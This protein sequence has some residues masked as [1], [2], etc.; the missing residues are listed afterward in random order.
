MKQAR[1]TRVN[2]NLFVALWRGEISII[3]SF[4]SS[5]CGRHIK[6]TQLNTPCANDDIETPPATASPPAYETPRYS[7]ASVLDVFRTL[8]TMVAVPA[9]KS[10][11]SLQLGSKEVNPHRGKESAEKK[12]ISPSPESGPPTVEAKN[13]WVWPARG[14][15]DGRARGGQARCGAGK[16]RE[17][18]A[19]GGEHANLRREKSN[20]N[21]QEDDS[22]DA[23]S[24]KECL[25][26][27][28]SFE[29]T[30][31]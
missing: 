2:A 19:T 10:T 30:C 3:F 23:I 14:G 26:A 28:V 1:C 27:D 17:D 29:S 11:P 24:R 15:G 22:T 6:P 21:E 7:D 12:V 9:R 31:R 18:G 8:E 16:E 13:V 4:I 5:C 25:T 20:E